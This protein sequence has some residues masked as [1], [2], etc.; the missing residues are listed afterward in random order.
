[1]MQFR[2]RG[3]Y[4]HKRIVSIGYKK[5]KQGQR[6]VKIY[7]TK[8]LENAKKGDVVVLGRVGKKNKLEIAKRAGSMGIVFQNINIKKFLKTEGKNESK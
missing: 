8:D 3:W 4:K 7:N 1:M 5:R 6:I 2:R